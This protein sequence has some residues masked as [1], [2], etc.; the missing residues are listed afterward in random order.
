M[1]LYGHSY[2][3]RS[4]GEL[5]MRGK[6]VH[7]QTTAQALKGGLNYLS[8]DRK[9]LGLVLMEDIKTNIAN[10]SYAKLSHWGIVN[11]AAEA[12]A[13]A[14]Y[15]EAL[16]IKTPSIYQKAQNL[17]GGNQQKVLIA[18][19]LLS[20]PEVFI[21][22]EP[23][24]G[25]DVGAKAEIYEILNGLASRGKSIILVTSELPEALA[26]ADRIYVMNEGKITGCL[27]H[28]EA[29]QEAIMALAIHKGDNDAR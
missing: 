13:A 24:R 5:F 21:F 6:K 19:A 4:T 18:R 17:S 23:T 26:M 11:K 9:S 12:H 25:I 8:E 29:S 27:S 22:D 2:G 14:E 15:A 10:S 28:D 1:S 7:F 3:S 20:E 16:K